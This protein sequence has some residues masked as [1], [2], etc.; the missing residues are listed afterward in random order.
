LGR[1]LSVDYGK[2]RIGLAVTDPLQ[3]IAVKLA[4]VSPSEVFRYL[5]DY[6][7][8]EEVEAIVIGYPKQMDNTES[9]SVVYIK[10]FIKKLRKDFPELE[11]HLFDERFTTKIALHALLEGKANRKTRR[12]KELKDQM[13]AIVL[14]NSFLDYRKHIAETSVS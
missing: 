8:R 9:E 3:L 4:T 6:F 14:L 13:S 1:I 11:V 12:N 10:P 5:K 7:L 2:K